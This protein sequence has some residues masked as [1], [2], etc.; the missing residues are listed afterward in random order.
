MPKKTMRSE[1]PDSRRD[2]QKPSGTK[3][4]GREFG[5]NDGE[6]KEMHKATCGDCNDIC[7]VPFK[8]NGKKKVLCRDCFKRSDTSQK[9]RSPY[10]SELNYSGKGSGN[11]DDKFTALNAKLDVIIQLLRKM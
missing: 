7:E 6:K 10:K 11:Y 9:T 5:G 3:S 4:W 8:P 2:K 1:R